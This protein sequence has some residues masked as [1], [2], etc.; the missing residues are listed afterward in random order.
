MADI[1]LT[2]TSTEQKEDLYNERWKMTE[3]L[4]TYLRRQADNMKTFDAFTK[5]LQSSKQFELRDQILSYL[6]RPPNNGK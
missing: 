4:I 2:L 6:K 1:C 5:S 3:T